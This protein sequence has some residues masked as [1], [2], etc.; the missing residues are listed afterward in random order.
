[1]IYEREVSGVRLIPGQVL[2]SRRALTSLLLAIMVISLAVQDSGMVTLDTI[3][4]GELG[5]T[6]RA[7]SWSFLSSAS[8]VDQLIE[9]LAMVW[10]V[11]TCA[12]IVVNSSALGRF[13]QLRTSLPSAYRRQFLVP[14][15]F[16]TYT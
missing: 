3:P 2:L 14:R 4:T 12:R 15:F 5:L 1:M 13:V 10:T 7:A 8:R 16:S 6:P 11:P 9:R